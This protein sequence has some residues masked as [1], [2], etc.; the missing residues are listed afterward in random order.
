MS[1][2]RETRN[3]RACESTD[4]GPGIE[5]RERERVFD[6]FYR[7]PGTQAVGS[8]L[9]L[10]IVRTIAN[11]HRAQVSLGSGPDGRGLLVTVEF[12]LELVVVG[13]GLKPRLSLL[14]YRD[15]HSGAATAPMIS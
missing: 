1:R 10:A 8:G 13:S 3:M 7:V 15:R 4:S 5:P 6:R 2:W 14:I 11:Q 12:A 9:G